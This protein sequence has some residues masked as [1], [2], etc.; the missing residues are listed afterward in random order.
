MISTATQKYVL[1]DKST[2][3]SNRNES[4]QYYA[5]FEN[6][7]IHLKKAIRDSDFKD[8]FSHNTERKEKILLM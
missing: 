1:S 5:P 4:F 7:S 6:I 2:M 3:K 8:Y